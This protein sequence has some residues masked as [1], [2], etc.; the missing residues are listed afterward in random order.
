LA[1]PGIEKL[2]CSA[3]FSLADLPLQRMATVATVSSVES[4]RDSA[5]LL[6]RM[7]EIGFLPGEPVKVLTRVPGGDPL[8]VRVGNSTFALRRCEAQ[9]V[10]VRIAEQDE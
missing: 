10:Q 5:S 8:A 6:R 9:C 7:A 4:D 1:I 2:S 3:L